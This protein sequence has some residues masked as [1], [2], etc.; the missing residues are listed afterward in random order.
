[1]IPIGNV[2]KLKDN[3]TFVALYEEG[4]I[5]N[6]DTKMYFTINEPVVFLMRG[7]S[8]GA[9]TVENLK[10]RLLER[11]PGVPEARV[12]TDLENLLN[13]LLEF[14]LLEEIVAERPPMQWGPTPPETAY[15]MYQEPAAVHGGSVDKLTAAMVVA[16]RRVYVRT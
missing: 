5:L 2:L 7:L 8:Q 16:P 6:T 1:M 13:K 9:L 14:Q 11:Y 15:S 10:E 3:C 12:T 4:L